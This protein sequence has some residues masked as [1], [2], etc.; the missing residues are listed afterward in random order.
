MSSE[1]TDRS[2]GRRTPESIFKGQQKILT[3]SHIPQ[4]ILWSRIF[5][6]CVC[7]AKGV[8]MLVFSV[9]GKAEHALDPRPEYNGDLSKSGGDVLK[10]LEQGCLNTATNPA[11]HNEELPAGSHICL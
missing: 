5:L 4:K 8:A 11:A 3:Q 9:P 7:T 1:R 2:T 6:W 10:S